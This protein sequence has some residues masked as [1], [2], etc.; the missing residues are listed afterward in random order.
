MTIIADGNKDKQ[1]EKPSN[2]SF[3]PEHN[4][5]DVGATGVQVQPQR[6]T[7]QQYLDEITTYTPAKPV[8]DP[9]RPEEL[10]RLARSN[11]IAKG[12]NLIGDMVSVQ[13]GGNVNVRRPDNMEAKYTNDMYK[14][15]DDYSRRTDQW[16]YRDWQGKMSAAKAG[17]TQANADRNFDA[18][19]RYRD[20]L[21]HQR[22]IDNERQ[23]AYQDAQVKNMNEDNKR[24][25]NSLN[26]TKRHN[27]AIEGKNN[28]QNRNYYGFGFGKDL[29]GPIVVKTR[30]GQEHVLSPQQASLLRDEAIN[31]REELI[32]IYPHLFERKEILDERKR[33][34][35]RYEWGLAKSADAVDLIRAFM[36]MPRKKES[37]DYWKYLESLNNDGE[38]VNVPYR[39]G[40]QPGQQ[41]K[42]TTT[43]NYG[44][45]KYE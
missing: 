31:N 10:R 18:Q 27:R 23:K 9:N 3:F 15:L 5:K 33:P 19:E 13:K 41:P 44:D 32:K 24:Q 7:A 29:K 34:T 45:L 39:Y 43:F 16:N 38:K 40:E 11:A 21:N 6:R 25:W 37:F 26:E 2:G 17:M 36:D 8:Y 1:R 28:D 20:E 14:Y 42:K 30:D 22:N 35:G 12:L 4:I